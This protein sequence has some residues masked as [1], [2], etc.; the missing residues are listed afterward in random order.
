MPDLYCLCMLI[1]WHKDCAVC[2]LRDKPLSYTFDNVTDTLL[3]RFS[4]HCLIKLV[5]QI[6]SFMSNW[7]TLLDLFI[8]CL[9]PDYAMAKKNL[10]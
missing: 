3:Q 10:C 6:G 4:V 5:M 9:T 1:L 7:L 8:L 2:S